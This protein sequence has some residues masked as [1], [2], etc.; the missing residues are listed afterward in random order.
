MKFLGKCEGKDW[1]IGQDCNK[2]NLIT[3]IG[4]G[5][6]IKTKSTALPILTIPRNF[7]VINRGKQCPY[8]HIMIKIVV[9]P[10]LIMSSKIGFRVY[11]F[12]LKSLTAHSGPPLQTARVS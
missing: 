10:A 8:I 9:V 5:D 2:R 1:W 6:Q 11:R 3:Y 7:Y 4:G 12:S